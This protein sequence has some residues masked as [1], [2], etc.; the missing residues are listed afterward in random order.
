MSVGRCVHNYPL[1]STP[2]HLFSHIYFLIPTLSYLLYSNIVP[3]TP[4]Y[5]IF[6]DLHTCSLSNT[7]SRPTSH[8]LPL[9]P[10]LSPFLS[11]PSSLIST[12]SHIF[13]LFRC[14]SSVVTYHQSHTLLASI[15]D[16]ATTTTATTS[17]ASTS[18]STSTRTAIFPPPQA[19]V[20]HPY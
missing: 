7:P 1:I 13:S 16:L 12:L 10:P 20:D 2:S 19:V 17:T 15:C 5:F 11:H 14:L 8:V 3:L 9:S 4:I 6:L 18:T